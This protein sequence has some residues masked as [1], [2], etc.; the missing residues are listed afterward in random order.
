MKGRSSL[1][2]P[3]FLV[4]VYAQG[5]VLKLMWSWELDSRSSM[6]EH[7]QIYHLDRGTLSLSP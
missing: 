7:K 6:R 2:T 3:P 4:G 1:E 5:K